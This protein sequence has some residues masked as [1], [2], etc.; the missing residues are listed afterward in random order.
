MDQDTSGPE[1]D[2]NPFSVGEV[3]LP[4]GTSTDHH[5]ASLALTSDSDLSEPKSF[6]C[7]VDSDIVIAVLRHSS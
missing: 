6:G 1:V 4:P 5:A 2:E 7:D 3:V